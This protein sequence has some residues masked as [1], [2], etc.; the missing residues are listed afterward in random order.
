MVDE[1]INPGAEKEERS[2]ASRLI[3][4]SVM[5]DYLAAK[6]RKMRARSHDEITR[7][8]RQHCKPFHALPIG[9]LTRAMVASRLRTIAEDGGPAAADRTRSTLS[10]TYALGHRGRATTSG[11]PRHRDQQGAATIGPRDPRAMSDAELG[12]DSGRLRHRT[13][14]SGGSC[15]LLTLHGAAMLGGDSAG[16]AG[17]RVRHRR[18]G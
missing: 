5:D 10:A 16:C 18:Q 15:R 17:L 6:A 13:A 12:G 4:S 11:K 1:G 7:H 9:G 8:L 14:P 2:E 3:F